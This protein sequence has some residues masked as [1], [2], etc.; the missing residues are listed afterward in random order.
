MKKF[1]VT[2][3]A[4]LLVLPAFAQKLY[5]GVVRDASGAPFEGAV[6]QILET[7]AAA[8]TNADGAFSV[9][10]SKGQTMEVNCIGMKTVTLTVPE[11]GPV[12]VVLQEDTQLIEETVVVGY[13]V[14]KKRDL[15]GSVTS[16]KA[17]EVKAG[18]ITS[19]EDLIKG[20]AA[21]VTVTQNSS[22][23]DGSLNIR[24][25]GAASLG[26]NNDPL[27]VVDGILTS[28][29][30]MLA[31]EDIE[32][33]EILKD[34]A[35]TAIYGARG[36]NGVVIIT[37]KRGHHDQFSVNYSYSLSAKSCHNNIDLMDAQD[38]MRYGNKIW[39]ENGKMGAQP[40]PEKYL[41]Y[42][43]PGTDWIKEFS[44]T[45]VTQTHAVSMTGGTEKVQAAATI[46]YHDNQGTIQNTDFRRLNGRVNVDFTP[47]KWL[48]AGIN[49]HFTRSNGTYV[50]MDIASATENAMYRLLIVSPLDKN[51]DSGL[52]WIGKAQFGDEI[53]RYFRNADY[54]DSSMEAVLS[55]YGE[56]TFW[57]KLSV[58][59]Q[60]ST[61]FT[62]YKGQNYL[63]RNTQVGMGKNGIATVSTNDR[64]YQQVDGLV[65]YHDNF[66]GHHDLKLIAGTS[67][68][69]SVAE[70]LNASGSDFT[71]DAFRFYNLGAAGNYDSMG[72]WR[73]D[74][75]NL[76]FFG[77][78]EY[79]LLDRYIFNASIRA[80][81]ASNFGK[82]NKWGYFPGASAAWQLGD[83]SWMEWAK[84]ALSQLKLRA[85]WGQT[86]NDSIGSYRSLKTYSSWKAYTGLNNT[87][88]SL[89]LGSPGNNSLMWETTTQTDL[90]LDA[91]F[92]KGRVELS[93][94]YYDKL[95]TN[96]LNDVTISYSHLGIGTTVGNLGSVSNKGYEIF[97]KWHIV[98]KKNF[99]W[100]TNVAF[101]YNKSNIVDINQKKHVAV[102][103]QG[104]YES[105][106]Y[107]EMDKGLPLAA[108][109]GYKCIGILQKGETYDPQPKSQPGDYIFEDVDPNGKIDSDDKTMLGVGIPP[110]ALGWGH[111]FR[112]YGFDATVFFDG[113]FG[114]SL[115][116]LSKV[117]LEDKDRLR[118]CFD[119]WTKEN[120]STTLGRSIWEK[121]TEY[122]YG[123][124]VNSNYVEKSDFLR[125]SNLEIG[126]TIPVEK[127]KI[128]NAIKAARVF[129]GGQRLF[130]LTKYSGFD[131]EVS[132]GGAS[133]TAHGLDW[134]AY[135]P[136]KTFNCGVNV[137]F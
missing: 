97:L 102:R 132:S 104:A 72:S 137:T 107:I 1:L 60:Y 99:S 71:T 41:E 2:C 23:P 94:D 29:G 93:L 6:V 45:G 3:F 136:F 48:K 34:A 76:S 90:G 8:V 18:V 130:T 123:S 73:D 66:A 98:D 33:I 87:A 7:R 128:N 79:V 57:K 109:Y 30:N 95:T 47:V 120:P 110:M 125:L 15:A 62:Y 83:E 113:S 69:K 58:R 10:A 82:N 4:A 12:N 84:P 5:T 68:R 116:N 129:V 108:I 121:T 31:P 131:P 78:A 49:S 43:G 118:T 103:P 54:H 80:D 122:Q 126:Y 9:S 135:P 21:G 134:A 91:I 92:F 75:T 106:N 55:G 63:N 17:E 67:Y 20:R 86:G 40:F 38:E 127:L 59:G 114:G 27:Y 19:P 39:E 53:Q 101:S 88:S 46:N 112:F 70:S 24:I 22:A 13:G 42:K 81:G 11:N 115:L 35:S 36:A 14:T 111:T 100:S 124:F 16:I 44:R 28:P 37:T 133:D 64:I 56:A 119:R 117:V 25:R 96:L 52:T 85:S 77:R 51:D 50:P 32:S 26:T 61:K 65:T 105:H 74:K 89:Y